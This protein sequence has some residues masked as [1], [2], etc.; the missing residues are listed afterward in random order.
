MLH[1]LVGRTSAFSTS[2]VTLLAPIPPHPVVSL[3]QNANTTR[4]TTYFIWYHYVLIHH[5]MWPQK[6]APLE[7]AVKLL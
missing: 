6:P 1:F 4:L 3:V 5:T 2:C 7:L